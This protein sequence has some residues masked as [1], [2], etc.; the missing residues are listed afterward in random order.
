[1]LY[2]IGG[3]LFLIGI[4]LLI[5]NFTVFVFTAAN[6]RLLVADVVLCVAGAFILGY[7]AGKRY[8]EDG[9]TFLPRKERKTLMIVLT[10][11][12]FVISIGVI[13]F[14]R[15]E[16]YP[17]V[18]RVLSIPMQDVI[19]TSDNANLKY[20]LPTEP[21]TVNIEY[22]GSL[23]K[24]SAIINDYPIRATLDILGLSV[25]T[26]DVGLQFNL[27]PNVILVANSPEKL[28]V[29]IGE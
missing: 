20:E 24:L 4:I 26:H 12:I 9:V 16:A 10:C 3:L 5:L 11:L 28:R 13:T 6:Y 8:K 17:T 29:V 18:R 7:T 1:M 19:V 27:P 2:A 15:V 23:E 14:I 22:H 25:G 21:I